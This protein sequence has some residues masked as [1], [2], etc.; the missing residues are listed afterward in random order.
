VYHFANG[1]DD[2]SDGGDAIVFDFARFGYF[3]LGPAPSQTSAATRA[4]IDLTSGTVSLD[5]YDD[6]LTEFPRIDDRLQT[7]AHRFFTVSGKTPGRPTF[8]FNVLRRIDTQ[9]GAITEWDS[10]TKVF[11]EVVFAPAAGGEPEQGYYCAFR[12]DVETLRSEWFVLDAA[13][14]AAGPIATV[15]LPFRVPN[16]LHGNW[17]PAT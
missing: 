6:R 7:T 16:G 4:R 15:E 2:S 5:D 8:E 11:D 14:I 13:D 17:F 12:T 3:A 1:F 10:G 9:T